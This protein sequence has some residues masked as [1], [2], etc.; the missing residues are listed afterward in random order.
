MS[1]ERTALAFD[2]ACRRACVRY[3][4][5]GGVAVAAW[6]EPRA[7]RDVDAL[8]LADG[9]AGGA[10]AS[11]MSSEGMRVDRASLIAALES[12]E[13]LSVLDA[14]TGFCV[15]L[16]QARG[17][18]A[19]EVEEAAEVD[20]AG[21]RLC[22][23]RAE[24]T[25]ASKLSRLPLDLQDARSILARRWGRLDVA[26]LDLLAR[27]RG[28]DAVLRALVDEVGRSLLVHVR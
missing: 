17:A 28:A 16:R 3:A 11:A 10:L 12:G 24:E 18:Q 19:R 25:I 14:H 22:I 9:E 20:L 26:R 13:P 15:D 2:R 5:V 4:F 8:V 23:V 27:E 7:T 21:G 6:G 1:I